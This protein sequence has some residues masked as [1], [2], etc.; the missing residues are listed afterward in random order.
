MTKHAKFSE[1]QLYVLEA[2]LRYSLDQV[3]D[4]EVKIIDWGDGANMFF[5]PAAYIVSGD[6]TVDEAQMLKETEEMLDEA[7]AA[8]QHSKDELQQTV[9]Y[10]I[11]MIIEVERDEAEYFNSAEKLEAELKESGL[12]FPPALLR[13]STKVAKTV[14]VTEA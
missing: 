1:K 12:D 10:S 14:K 5:S 13:L 6:V 7:L 3:R 11:E 2:A 8:V 4:S 9:K